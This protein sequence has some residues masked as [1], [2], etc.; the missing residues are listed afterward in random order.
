MKMGW[1]ISVTT[2]GSS[3][4]NRL[5][6]LPSKSA[7]GGWCPPWANAVGKVGV[8]RNRAAKNATTIKKLRQ[9]IFVLST[10]EIFK[11]Q[12]CSR[13]YIG[14]FCGR[15]TPILLRSEERRVGKECRSRW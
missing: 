6:F 5:A 2:G 3:L 7:A 4:T 9:E 15:T 13:V 8:K 10:W 11:N 12:N 14:Y 1:L